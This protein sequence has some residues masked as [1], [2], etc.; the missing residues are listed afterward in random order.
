MGATVGDG[1]DFAVKV[2][3]DEKS[4]AIDLDRN[5]IAGSNIIGLEYGDPFFLKIEKTVMRQ[6]ENYYVAAFKI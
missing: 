1:K 4:K 2:G 5:K 6:R 3:G